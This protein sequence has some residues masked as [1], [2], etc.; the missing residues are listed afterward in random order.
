MVKDSSRAAS[1]SPQGAPKP[2]IVATITLFSVYIS[3]QSSEYLQ[4]N[5]SIRGVAFTMLPA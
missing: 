1:R 2:T 4:R 5:C 3:A